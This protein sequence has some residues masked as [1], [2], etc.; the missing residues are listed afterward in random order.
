MAATNRVTLSR[1]LIAQTAIELIDS[2]GFEALS[3]R[4]LGSALGVEAMSLYHYVENKDDLLDAIVDNLYAELTLPT[5]ISADDW[6]QAFRLGLHS[7]YDVLLRHPAALRLFSLRPAS[8]RNALVVMSW[9]FERCR[10][11][12]LTPEQAAETF[13]YCVSYVMGHAATELGLTARIKSGE[14]LAEVFGDTDDPD[15]KAFLLHVS[16][17]GV[18]QVFEIGLDTLLNGLAATYGLKRA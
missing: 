3:M 2:E 4:K 6:E 16:E 5:D 15:F 12:G 1:E 18:N 10:M 8:S 9:A 13:H 7:F 17:V 11:V 14:D